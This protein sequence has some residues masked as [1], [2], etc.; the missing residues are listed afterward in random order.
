MDVVQTHIYS[1]IE[2]CQFI[3]SPSSSQLYS[4]H[5]FITY[6]H[7]HQSCRSKPKWNNISW[8][9][10]TSMNE[11]VHNIITHFGHYNNTFNPWNIWAHTTSCHGCKICQRRKHT[12][13]INKNLSSMKKSQYSSI[14]R[15]FIHEEESIFQWEFIV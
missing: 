8:H 5:P 3:G 6:N 7:G 15:P 4:I 9:L 11:W 2:H 12:S 13:S 1:S 10:C 14:I